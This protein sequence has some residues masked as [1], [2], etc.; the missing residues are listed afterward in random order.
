LADQHKKA[1]R[2]WGRQTGGRGILQM[3][4]ESFKSYGVGKIDYYKLWGHA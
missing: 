3:I 4:D 2:H 1:A